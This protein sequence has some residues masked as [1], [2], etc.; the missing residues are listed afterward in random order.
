MSS[1]KGVLLPSVTIS[2]NV[3]ILFSLILLINEIAL[4]PSFG[5]NA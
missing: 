4:P 3:R 1:Q 5:G 2:N